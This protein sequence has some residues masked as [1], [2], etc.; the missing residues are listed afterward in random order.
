MFCTMNWYC[1]GETCRTKMILT[2]VIFFSAFG[3]K[4]YYKI[5]KNIRTFCQVLLF[6]Y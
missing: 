1:A 2:A 6:A 4:Q 3:G 5:G